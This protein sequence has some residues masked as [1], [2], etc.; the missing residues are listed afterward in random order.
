MC[1]HPNLFEEPKVQSPF[2]LEPI[3]CTFPAL[4]LTDFENDPLT[5]VRDASR[6]NVDTLSLPL[7]NLCFVHHE[8]YGFKQRG[9]V[10]T[11]KLV[12]SITQL[13]LPVGAEQESD[14]WGAAGAA[15]EDPAAQHPIVRALL[16]CKEE[17]Q[18]AVLRRHAATNELRTAAGPL[19]GESLVEFLSVYEVGCCLR[20]SSQSHV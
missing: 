4:V 13:P 14:V 15:G 11:P 18:R 20:S 7:L 10:C 16:A 17:E 12:E 9:P 2:V 3:R 19:Y 5:G 8:L 6:A 1:N